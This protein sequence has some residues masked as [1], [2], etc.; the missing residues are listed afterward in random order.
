MGASGVFSNNMTDITGYLGGYTEHVSFANNA[1]TIGMSTAMLILMRVKMRFKTKQIVGGGLAAMALLVFV[2]GTTHNY[3]VFIAAN[4][5]IGF[6][7]MFTLLEIIIIVMFILAPD[8]NR[9]NFYAIFYPIAIGS[10]TIMFNALSKL[11]FNYGIESAYL[12]VSII[13]LS[14]SALAII[15]QHDKQFGFKMPLYQVDWF[16]MFLFAGSLMCLNYVLVFCKQQNWFNSPYII[17]NS[18]L[19]I[20]LFVWLI[21]RQRKLKRKLIHFDMFKLPNVRHGMVLIIFM[22]IYLSST[23]VYM[24]WNMAALGYNNLIN[25]GLGLWGLPT[26]ILGGVLAFIGFKKKWNLKYFIL[27]GFSAFFVHSLMIYFLIQPQMNYEHFYLLIM[28]RN[29]GMVILFIGAWQ[30][31]TSGMPQEKSMGVTAFLVMFRTFV[32]TAFGGAIIAFVSQYFQ[33]QSMTDMGNYW[34]QTMMGPAAMRG[35]GSMQINS[36]LNGGKTLMGWMCWLFIP[37]AIFILNH[38]YGNKN[39][40]KKVYFKKLLKRESVKGYHY[41]VN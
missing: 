37:I 20:A 38:D 16:S 22:G 7:K 14:L 21:L 26:L 36:L 18:I 6:F 19:A 10:S 29:F 12:L 40:R 5:L 8:G 30:Y 39:L 31:A 34:D 2:C 4:F 25:A 23:S 9:K 1:L 13:L 11:V 32:A 15:F 17:W 24:Q 28:V 35:F 41:K 27:L 3:Y 33:I